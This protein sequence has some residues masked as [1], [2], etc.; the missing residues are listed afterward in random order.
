[1]T[2]RKREIYAKNTLLMEK[3]LG[4]I[5]PLVTIAV[6]SFNQGCFLDE[7]LSSIFQ[8][9]IPVEVFVLDGGSTD[10][11]IEI[12]RKWEHKL[13]G[14]R[15]YVDNGQA[16]AINEGIANGN[17]PYVCW[18][19][20][21]DFFLPLGLKQLLA[22]FHEYPEAPAVYGR[23]WNL[24]H[25][26]GKQHPVWVEPFNEYRL[27]LRC[28][29]SQPATLIRRAVWNAVGGLN[30]D[31]HM[32]MDYDL[33]WR[34]YR[35]AGPLKFLDTFVAINRDHCNTKTTTKR[36]MHYQEA[37]SVVRKH[38]GRAPLKWWLAQPYAVWFKSGKHLVSILIGC[39]IRPRGKI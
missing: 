31:L 7:T 21:D 2:L 27:A 24:I 5:K 4:T 30:E 18:L 8:Q 11:S 36:N 10:N 6:P 39:M 15:S 25:K 28:I 3:I 32:T 19:N 20:S 33:W 38:Y 22:K 35:H 26:S 13:A 29:I 1:M 12:I 14:W 17:A 34:L 9:E 37:I 16:A 23:S